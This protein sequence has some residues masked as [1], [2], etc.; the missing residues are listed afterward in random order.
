MLISPAFAQA[1]GG[2]DPMAS[3]MQF[4]PLILIF[5]VFYMLMIRP[6]QKRMKE[7][8]AKLASIRRGDRV[9]TGGGLIAT[10]AKVADDELII[11]LA[12]GV[13]VKVVR[14]TIADVM[15]KTDPAKGG[16]A[17][18]DDSAEDDAEEEATAPADGKAAGLKGLLSKK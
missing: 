1:A 6:Q 3:V 8:K 9:M 7:H 11:D 10:V 4:L 13:R 14:S 15:A 12:E 17:S 5:G 2:G 18:K 16:K